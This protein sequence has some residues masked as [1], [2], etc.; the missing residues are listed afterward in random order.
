MLNK[1]IMV[2]V[3]V[4]RAE[5]SKARIDTGFANLSSYNANHNHYFLYDVCSVICVV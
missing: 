4:V 5:I 2:I 3:C 1:K